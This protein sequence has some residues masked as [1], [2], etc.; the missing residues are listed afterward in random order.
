[1]KTKTVVD[2]LKNKFDKD[3]SIQIGY[4]SWL[5]RIEYW[6]WIEGVIAEYSPSKEA[7]IKRIKELLSP[8]YVHPVNEGGL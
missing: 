6:L 2:L 8:N 3:V 1:M 7:L 5:D 4:N